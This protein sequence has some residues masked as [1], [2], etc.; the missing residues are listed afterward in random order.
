MRIKWRSAII[1]HR[2]C[3]QCNDNLS[4]AVAAV[5]VV[6]MLVVLVHLERSDRINRECNQMKC[7][8][9]PYCTMTRNVQWKKCTLGQKEANTHTHIW[10]I[11]LDLETNYRV[12]KQTIEIN[13]DSLSLS[14]LYTLTEWL[15]VLLL[16]SSPLPSIARSTGS[17]RSNQ[18]SPAASRHPLS[19]LSFSSYSARALR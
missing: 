5:V 16:S 15:P 2:A 14:V 3:M 12:L 17:P 10:T 11:C 6:A 18:S 13:G 19:Y 7:R 9:R 1:P 8:R 4:M